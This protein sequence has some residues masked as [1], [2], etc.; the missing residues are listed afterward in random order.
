MDTDLDSKL[1]DKTGV[2][3]GDCGCHK[4]HKDNSFPP[5]LL[6]RETCLEGIHA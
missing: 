1:G 6:M 4:D 3:V 5:G 2:G